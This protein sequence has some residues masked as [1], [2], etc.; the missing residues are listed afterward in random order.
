MEFPGPEESCKVREN[1]TGTGM[2]DA[3]MYKDVQ[4]FERH[5]YSKGEIGRV[6][7]LDPKTVAK[8]FGM[9]E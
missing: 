4:V 6:L 5:G 7:R 1:L 8:Y 3:T 2:I 9:R